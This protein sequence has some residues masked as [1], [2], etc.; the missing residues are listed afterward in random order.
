MVTHGDSKK[1]MN[2]SLKKRSKDSSLKHLEVSTSKDTSCVKP[3]SIIIK[4]HATSQSQSM[5]VD[6]SLL[7]EAKQREVEDYYIKIIT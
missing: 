6:E 5:T 3:K 7:F 4:R 2:I 1:K